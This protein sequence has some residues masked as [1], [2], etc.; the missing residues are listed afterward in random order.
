[1]MFTQP[2][3]HF[4]NRSGKL[5]LGCFVV[6]A[7]QYAG[8]AG[9]H[10]QEASPQRMNILFIMSDDH[11]RNATSCY[12]GKIVKTPHIDRLAEQGVKFTQA[13]SNNS[14][15]SPAR[16]NLLTG[17]YSHLS[18]VKRL[19]INYGRLSEK[20]DGKQVTFPKLLQGAGYQ[21]AVIGKWHLGSRPT[22]FDYFAVTPFFG[23][24]FK[25]RFTIP[26][27]P[28]TG[29]D[30]DGKLQTDGYFTDATTD[31]ALDWIRKR[32][33]KKPFCMLLQYRAPHA[34]FVPNKKHQD[35]FKDRVFPEPGNLHDQFEGRAPAH[36]K[37]LHN[38]NMIQQ[39]VIFGGAPRKQCNGDYD[40]DVRILYQDFMRRYARMVVSLDENIGRVMD[41]LDESGLAKNTV[42]I[43]TTD[44]GYFTGEHG[45]FN[46]MWM[47]EESIRLPLIVRSPKVRGG[48]VD[49][50]IVSMVD[51]APTLLDFAGVTVPAEM[52]G[53]SIKPLLMNPDAKWDNE[54]YYH[55]YGLLPRESPPEMIGI[56]TP[57]AK[58]VFYPKL[59][60]ATAFWEYFDLTKDQG[61][62]HNLYHHPDYKEK[63]K[64]MKE[65]LYTLASKYQDREALELIGKGR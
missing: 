44:N 24:S 15:C 57:Y 64:L 42:V 6:A 9:T 18:S 17:K 12:G 46:K 20:F 28:W 52:Q 16:A 27:Q 63:V 58:L 45:Y 2:S 26:D 37:D 3:H 38:N 56:R 55:Y 53:K 19:I 1:M 48:Q 8:M 7:L 35:L 30:R 47:Y 22:G 32:D 23:D 21:T 11:G 40:H 61:D 14:V 41:Y 65:K 60:Q 34:P 29:K 31:P 25:C 13:F 33:T 36:C 49:S 5:V 43:Y 54:L 10:A 62:M 39:K 4:T 51:V 50:H 59:D